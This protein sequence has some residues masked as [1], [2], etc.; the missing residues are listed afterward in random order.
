MTHILLAYIATLCYLASAA[1]IGLRLF[2]KE[3]WIPPR[4]LAIAVGF[5]GLVLH[6]WLLWHGIFSHAGINLGFY[7]ALALTSWTIVALLLVSSLTKPVDNLGLI[8]LPVAA[9]PIGLEARF[10]EARKAALVWRPQNT[11]VV[12]DETGEKILK[13]VNA[14]EDN[15]DVQNV[16]ANFEISEALMAKLGG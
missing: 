6:S 12:D 9:L 3:G 15:D 16:Y 7:H 5:G 13:L 14:L 1:F 4:A 10:G 8:L 2:R 11:I